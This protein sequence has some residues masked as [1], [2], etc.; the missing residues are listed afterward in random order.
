MLNGRD[1]MD[2]ILLGILPNSRFLFLVAMLCG[3]SLL[4][5]ARTHSLSCNFP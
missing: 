1:A 3:R 4:W 2:D 5:L